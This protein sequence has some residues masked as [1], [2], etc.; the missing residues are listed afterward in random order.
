MVSAYVRHGALTIQQGQTVTE[1][2][3]C[4]MDCHL[5]YLTWAPDGT[6][7]AYFYGPASAQEPFAVRVTDLSGTVTTVAEGVGWLTPPAWSPNGAHLA[8]L[9]ATDRY[10]IKDETPRFV[11]EVWTSEITTDST[12]FQ[13]RKRGEVSIGGD[14]GG[15]GRSESA[16]RYEVEGGLA[17]GGY[18]AGVLAWTADDIL[19]YSDNCSARGV[20]RFDLTAGVEMEPYPGKLSS[21]SLNRMRDRWVA[22]DEQNQLV[23]G[24]PANLVY[25]SLTTEA[26]PELAF[27]GQVTDDLYYTVLTMTGKADLFDGA[28]EAQQSIPVSPYFEF[29]QP[30]LRW[31]RLPALITSEEKLLFNDNGYAYG[32]VQQGAD[33]T[34]YF[35]RVSNS[36][37]I[38]QAMQA[39]TLTAEMIERLLPTVDVLRLLPD[40][41]RPEVWIAN[42]SQYTIAPSMSRITIGQSR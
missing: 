38:H 11:V 29:T 42:V 34:I 12:P 19:L 17:Y 32:R 40:S 15:G 33:G 8:Y 2:E 30:E 23:L 35:G 21:L 4:A 24:S 7:L 16:A 14:C 22:I 28:S 20:G 1:I 13:A 25:E 37:A 6:R 5:Y 39:G 10:V 3:Q 31:L 18:L 27:Y 26:S 36:E 41:N 9:V